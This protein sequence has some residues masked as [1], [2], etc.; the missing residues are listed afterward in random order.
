MFTLLSLVQ[1]VKSHDIECKWRK[2]DGE[3]R[4]EFKIERQTGGKETLEERKE[5][6]FECDTEQEA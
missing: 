5:E 2:V 4:Q 3:G 1:K 6:L